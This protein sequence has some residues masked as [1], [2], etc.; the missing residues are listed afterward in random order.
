M[1]SPS[2]PLF[3]VFMAPTALADLAPVLESGRLASGPRVGEFETRLA[4]WLGAHRTVA[5]SDASG[6][7]MLAM[8]LAGVRP[9]DEVI[10]SPLACAATLMPI[11]NLFAKPVWCDVDP[12]TGM[13]TPEGVARFIGP[14]TK[15]VLLYHWSGNVGD[16]GTIGDVCRQRGIKLVQDASEAFGAEYHGRHLGAEADFT[17][18]SF[19]ATKHINC[20]E[21]AALLAADPADLETALRLR[22]FGVDYAKLRLPDG[23][24]NPDFDIQIAGYNL[25]MSEIAASIVS[26]ALPHAEGIVARH[27]AN[28]RY[29]ERALA[30][31]PGI[32]LLRQSADSASSYWT[33]SLCADRRD[34]LIRRL[35]A[36]G[37]GAQRLHV[38]NDGYSC[39]GGERHD[40]AGVAALDDANLSIPCGWWVSDED[41]ARVV[42]VIREGW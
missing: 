12:D 24:L 22:R 25:A 38:R 15:A 3:K 19:Y 34:G 14:R 33:Y 8:Y 28:G 35:H 4:E 20:G 23:N 18:Y 42:E 17:V 29:F 11:A 10:T 39:F 21:G 41:R 26:A 6:A 32:R 2:I 5:L 1:A 13:P 37:I 40:L 31:I 9:G 36:C 16:V 30:D 27:R 7:L